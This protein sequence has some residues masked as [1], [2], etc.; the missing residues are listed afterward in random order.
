[1]KDLHAW[2]N[3]EK[4]TIDGPQILADFLAEQNDPT[5]TESLLENA[6]ERMRSKFEEFFQQYKD[7]GSYFGQDWL[8]GIIFQYDQTTK[9]TRSGSFLLRI[10]PNGELKIDEFQLVD[11]DAIFLCGQIDY[12]RANV[13]NSTSPGFKLLDLRTKEQI[14]HPKMTSDLTAQEAIL[15]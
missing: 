14:I 15:E 11:L 5:I 10:T 6:G 3:S 8:R 13:T 12:V 7:K 2:L 4:P 1:V 9:Q